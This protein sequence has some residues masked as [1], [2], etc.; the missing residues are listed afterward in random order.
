MYTY[1]E[2]KTGTR[3][4]NLIDSSA[5][6]KGYI[7]QYTE[8]QTTAHNA[9]CG[10]DTSQRKNI[11]TMI[12]IIKIYNILTLTTKNSLPENLLVLFVVTRHRNESSKSDSH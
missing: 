8:D 4:S 2:N 6:S 11:A 1:Y 3:S 7:A 9:R 12:K 10:I 5:L